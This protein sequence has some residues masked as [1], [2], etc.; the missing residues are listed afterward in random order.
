[1]NRR[2]ALRTLGALPGVLVLPSMPFLVG[3]DVTQTPK[4]LVS[5]LHVRRASERGGADHGWLKAQHSFSFA[6]YR[7]PKHMGF[8]DLRVLNEDIIAPG[9]GFPMHPHRDM[10]I[11]TYVLSGALEHKDSLGN[12]S[13]IRPGEVQAMSAGQG[14]RHSEF[15]PSGSE[16]V[17]LLQIWMLPNAKG[18][19]ARYQQQKIKPGSTPLRLI[20]SGSHPDASVHVHQ[21]VNIHACDLQPRQRLEFEVKPSRHTWIQVAR[22]R[23]SINGQTLRAGD[24]LNTHE[25]GWLSIQ[26]DREA[27]HLMIFDLS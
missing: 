15:N 4:T 3:C 26:A 24:G 20:A 12:G 10:E 22:G 9:G 11:L 5:A 27:A 23:L 7:D 21:D 6:R 14:V 8:R 2:D 19:K 16:P 17:H 1:M 13:I 18:H 25:A